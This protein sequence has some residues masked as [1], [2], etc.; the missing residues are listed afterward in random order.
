MHQE[1]S[2]IIELAYHSLSRSFSYFMFK[3]D[4]VNRNVIKFGCST[5]TIH[6]T[7]LNI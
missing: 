2:V 4:P 1:M 3:I 5:L 6:W 7:V